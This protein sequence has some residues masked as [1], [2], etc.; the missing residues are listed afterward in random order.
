MNASVST[1]MRARLRLE[2]LR[3]KPRARRQLTALQERR[4]ALDRGARRI[5][6][7]S[8]LTAITGLGRAFGPGFGIPRESRPVPLT[9]LSPIQKTLHLECGMAS[10][11]RVRN[12]S[13]PAK[14]ILP[15]PVD[16]IQ[17]SRLFRAL[18]RLTKQRLTWVHAPAGGGQ[19]HRDRHSP[20]SARP[21]RALVRS[22]LGRRRRRRPVSLPTDR[23]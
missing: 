12:R 14:L 19:D 17:R 10:R 6:P 11:R 15:D 4:R 13:Q 22:R 5:I 18:D 3:G 23:R 9:D 20:A 8:A 2:A 1:C 21:P 16:A 7:R